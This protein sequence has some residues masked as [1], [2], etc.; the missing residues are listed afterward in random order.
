MNNGF[1]WNYTGE[2]DEDGMACGFG[3]IVN[4]KGW[5]TCRFKGIFLNDRGHGFGKKSRIDLLKSVGTFTDEARGARTVTS[6]F[7]LGTFFGKQT[8]W[9]K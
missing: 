7:Y 3:E 2:I 8:E 6:E 5:D 1:K 9:K 4:L